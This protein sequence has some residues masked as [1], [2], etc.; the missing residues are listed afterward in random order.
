MT[1]RPIGHFPSWR[2][3]DGLWVC[4]T[5]SMRTRSDLALLGVLA[6]PLLLAA[7]PAEPNGGVD[8]PPQPTASPSVS[9]TATASAAAAS[10]PAGP[11][12]QSP[13]GMWMPEQMPLHEATLKSLGMK[14]DPGSLARLDGAPVAAVVSL[15]GCTGSFVS[16]DGLV[17]TNHHCV[18]RW[19][20]YASSP[21]KDYGV[22]G[23]NAKARAEEVWAGP[24]ARVFVT[25]AIRDVTGEVREGIEKIKGDVERLRAVEK[26]TKKLVAACEKD[27]PSV[28]CTVSS[29][30]GGGAFRLIEQLEM[31]DVR[32]AYVPPEGVGDYGGEIDNWRWPRHGGDFAFFRVYVG[33]DGGPA[34]RA[35]TNVPYKSKVFLPFATSPLRAGDLALMAGYPASTSRLKI[36]AD[37][38][39][40]ATWIFPTRIDSYAAFIPLLDS[41]AAKSKELQIKTSSQI[42]GMNNGLTKMRGV[43]EALAKG[44]RIADRKKAEAELTAWIDADAT[45]KAAW[46]GVVEAMGARIAEMKKHREHDAAVREILAT[47]RLLGSAML[48]VRAAE[49]R[50]KPDADRHPDYQERN[51][52]RIADETA[53]LQKAYDRSVEIA[54]LDLAL[55][56]TRKAGNWPQFTSGFLA[57]VSDADRMKR[58]TGL[59]DKTKLEDLETRK[60]LLLTSKIADLKKLKDPLIDFAL[61]ARPEQKEMQER[62][63][64]VAGAFLL[65]APKYAEASRAFAKSKGA[66]DIAP[67]AN[68]TLRVTFGTVQGYK[69]KADAPMYTPFTTLAELVKKHT[70]KTPF[71][72]PQAL[73]DAEKQGRKGPYLFA[74][75]GDVPVDFLANLD[76]TGGNSGSPTLN[77]K[78]ELVGL[79]FDTTYEGVASDWLYLP[80]TTRSIHVDAR[81]MLWV[82]DAVSGAT[83]LLKELGQKPAFAKP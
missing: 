71:D 20:S 80:E 36:A 60:K 29:F 27:R 4:Y 26:H 8:A 49:E 13:G 59:Y 64:A 2:V 5:R 76:L 47:P 42:G 38:E 56:R 17:V 44:G 66:A 78:G 45:R 67:D 41:F 35:E 25:Q 11:A 32:L 50:A 33:K 19:L 39:E 58:V 63:E 3:S 61:S 65:L 21:Q 31:K 83:E 62:E 82:I 79:A 75:I 34:D 15:G 51:Y 55:E 77:A 46:G 48:I 72:A 68:G 74:D 1:Q 23:V 22:D 9:A 52:K 14:I 28:K 70:G 30:F 57:K 10:L 6:V 53:A 81:Y 37:V 43:V 7:C 16:P 24:N 18:A 12:Y 54:V 69:P 73:L 40:T